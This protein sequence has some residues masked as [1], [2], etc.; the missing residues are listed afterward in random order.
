MVSGSASSHSKPACGGRSFGAASNRA[1]SIRS[2]RSLFQNA[3][4]MPLDEPGL[5]LALGFDLG[6][7]AGDQLFQLGRGFVLQDEVL[8]GGEA[9]LERVAG[10]CGPCLRG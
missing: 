2:A 9:V 8:Q 3:I 7:Q 4:A 5:D 1:T 6:H 10:G